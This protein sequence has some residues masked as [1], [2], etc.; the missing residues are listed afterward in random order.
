M[1]ADERPWHDRPQAL[2]PEVHA[3]T[4]MHNPW[5]ARGGAS[6][7]CAGAPSFNIATLHRS[8]CRWNRASYKVPRLTTRVGNEASGE[9]ART[10]RRPRK[11]NGCKHPITTRAST[12]HTNHHA[13]NDKTR[14]TCSATAGAR[15]TT[16]QVDHKSAPHASSTRPRA[17]HRPSERPTTAG[18]RKHASCIG[19]LRW[20]TSPKGLV[21]AARHPQGALGHALYSGCSLAACA[22]PWTSHPASGPECG[23]CWAR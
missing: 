13:N 3:T 17:R 10:M 12:A 11:A 14:T 21:L 18:R 6:G 23:D 5:H 7:C 16:A 15:T 4:C 9:N 20:R 2:S 8:A 19:F 22:G 1:F